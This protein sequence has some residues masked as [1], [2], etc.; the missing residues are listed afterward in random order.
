MNNLDVLLQIRIDPWTKDMLA[1]IAN[2]NDRSMSAQVRVLIR[3]EWKKHESQ[4]SEPTRF[5]VAGTA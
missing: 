4:Q 5:E 1:E 3:D 2:Q